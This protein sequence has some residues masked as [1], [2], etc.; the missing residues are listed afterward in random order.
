MIERI[1]NT[2][3]SK[4]SA[5]KS[6]N[7][8]ENDVIKLSSSKKTA[9]TKETTSEDDLIVLND[10][11][12]D[13]EDM[14]G[15]G[16]ITKYDVLQKKRDMQLDKYFR[17][18]EKI[19]DLE[20]K[21]AK[22]QEKI[23]KLKDDSSQAE[24]YQNKIKTI[25]NTIGEY[26]EK[27]SSCESN[28]SS[29]A[30]QIQKELTT[31]MEEELEALNKK[32]NESITNAAASMGSTGGINYASSTGSTGAAA[33]ST[34]KGGQTSA[35]TTSS[36]VNLNN[37]TYQ[38]ESIPKGIASGLDS[39]LG[40]GFSAKCEKVAGY[41]GCNVNDLLGMMYSESGLKPTA[42]NKSSNAVGL[43]QFI[44]STLKANGYT[45]EQVANMS[46][47]DQLDVVADIFMKSKKMAGYGENQKI[48][49]GTLYAINWLPAYAKNNTIVTS[50]N[51]YYSSGL[52]MDKNG[53]VTKSDLAKRL[54][55]KYNE[56]QR[57]L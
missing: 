33:S 24:L 42:R 49:G 20:A 11:E 28:L 31:A 32:L 6:I 10:L 52:D 18:Q 27:C 25:D 53:A 16:K 56:M 36:N 7:N 43:I 54:Q 19:T 15:D 44:P 4:T 45:T 39:K 3:V 8:N 50:S 22:Y 9:G 46:A 51:R 37:A 38:G 41:L 30:S 23:E 57:T 35:A 26:Q 17:Y 1:N 13:V 48:D 5:A 29:L 34:N 2:E 47:I 21:K 40:A 55:S 12:D 14:D